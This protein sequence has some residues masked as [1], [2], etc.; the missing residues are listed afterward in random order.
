MT[1]DDVYLIDNKDGTYTLVYKDKEQMKKRKNTTFR[2]S[3]AIEG[4]IEQGFE[5]RE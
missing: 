3:P 1:P 2:Y 5:V 4:M